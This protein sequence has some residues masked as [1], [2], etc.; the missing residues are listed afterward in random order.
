MTVSAAV[1]LT[2][3]PPERVLKRNS[4]GAS[5]ASPALWKRSIW[6][7]RSSGGVSPSIRQISQPFRSTAQSCAHVHEHWAQ[8]TE[9]GSTHLDDIQH[10]RKLA[11]KEHLVPA[12]EEL[13]EQ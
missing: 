11:E 8:E 6:S 9:Q 1:R 2:P 4:R 3:S 7:R 10:R 13:P 5:G 12:A